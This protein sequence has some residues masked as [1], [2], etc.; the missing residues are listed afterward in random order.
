MLLSTFQEHWRIQ[1]LE[2]HGIVRHFLTKRGSK[3]NVKVV[4]K[5]VNRGGGHGMDVPSIYIFVGQKTNIDMLVASCWI[6]PITSI[7]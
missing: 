4:G 7:C 5:A 6:F 1:G 2:L 3:A